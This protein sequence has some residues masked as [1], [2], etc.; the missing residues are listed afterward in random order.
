MKKVKS[1][2]ILWFL[3]LFT[4]LNAAD[5]QVIQRHPNRGGIREN[6]RLTAIADSYVTKYP[7]FQSHFPDW[8]KTLPQL[9]EREMFENQQEYQQNLIAFL[10]GYFQRLEREFPK[11]IQIEA[12]PSEVPDVI[13]LQNVQKN[14]YWN[15][16]PFTAR[17]VT[18]E[19]LKAG[20]QNENCLQLKR[21][22]GWHDDWMFYFPAFAAEVTQNRKNLFR[23]WYTETLEAL[24]E[25]VTFKEKALIPSGRNIFQPQITQDGNARK[26]IFQY[27]VPDSS[28][29]GVDTAEKLLD[30]MK[31]YGVTFLDSEDCRRRPWYVVGSFFEFVCVGRLEEEIPKELTEFFPRTPGELRGKNEEGWSRTWLAED[32]YAEETENAVQ[33]WLSSRFGYSTAELNGQSLEELL[34]ILSEN[35]KKVKPYHRFLKER[36]FKGNRAV[37]E[38][39]NSFLR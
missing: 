30:F 10:N 5:G 33:Y 29:Y 37:E 23:C 32:R 36:T 34:G 26:I 39:L 8:A 22:A 17:P 12:H 16:G 28:K 27:F 18:A 7:Q 15:P 13:F 19:N 14:P 24:L 31:K 2:L 1:T 25:E 9:K 3:L 38:F 35:L 21:I 4:V 6:A 20:E 11:K